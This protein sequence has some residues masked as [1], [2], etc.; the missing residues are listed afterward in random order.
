MNMKYKYEFLGLV[1]PERVNFNLNG[2]E[3]R[4]GQ[5]LISVPDWN[6]KGNFSVVIKNCKIIVVFESDDQYRVDTKV[7]IETLKNYIEEITRTFVDAYCFVNSYNYDVLI[8]SVKC[9]KIGLD[10]KFPVIGEWGYKTKNDDFFKTLDQ[11]M[12]LIKKSNFLSLALSDYRRSIKYPRTT[13]LYCLRAL[14]TI[15][16][17]CF[18]NQTIQDDNKRDKNGWENM[19]KNLSVDKNQDL[20]NFAKSNRHGN[21]PPISYEKRKEFM[22]YTRS[23]I[24]KFIEW[25][26]NNL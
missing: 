8:N 1:Y 23:T 24:E 2:L 26:K 3:N 11:I 14:E 22:Q 25:S 17:T 7:N 4:Y 12:L 21:Y 10:Y 16:R 5:M 19:K 13:A 20:L 18:D 15:R 6:I 9:E